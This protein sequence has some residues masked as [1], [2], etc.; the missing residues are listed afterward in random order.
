MSQPAAT[1]DRIL[2]FWFNQ[3]GPAKWYEGGP[4]FDA[5]V[6]RQFASAV[7]MHA[8]IML[9]LEPGERHDWQAEPWSA[10]ALI[11]LF[12]QFPRNVWRGSGRSFAYDGLAREVA[13]D[14]IERGYDWVIP[15]AQRDFIYLPFMH[16]ENLDDQIFSLS[17]FRERLDHQRQVPYALDHHAIIERFGRFPYRNA[18]L[19]R[20]TTEAETAW[21]TER[22]AG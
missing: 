7:E 11:I 22:T 2:D 6:R 4:A 19:Q 3:A 13:S 10:L 17:C 12:D 1:P 16:S 5:R 9:A 21:L 18:A 14:M 15:G 8:R 20:P